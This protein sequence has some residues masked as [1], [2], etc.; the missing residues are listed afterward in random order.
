MKYQ[1]SRQTTTDN[2]SNEVIRSTLS[3][4]QSMIAVH[5]NEVWTKFDE[6][7]SLI[8]LKEIGLSRI[9][10]QPVLPTFSDKVQHELL[11]GKLKID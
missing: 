1:R 2:T 10:D 3:T 7:D 9:P 6:Y 4:E 11:M 8:V 5:K